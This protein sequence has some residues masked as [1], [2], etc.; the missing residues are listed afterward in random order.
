[1]RDR[2]ANRFVMNGQF[3]LNSS[4]FAGISMSKNVMENN[5]NQNNNDKYTDNHVVID[6]FSFIISGDNVSRDYRDRE[7]IRKSAKFNASNCINYRC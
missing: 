5:Q 1:M 4:S 2:C 7:Y 3:S 6:K